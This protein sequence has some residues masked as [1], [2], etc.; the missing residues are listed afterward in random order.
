[1]AQAHWCRSHSE[2]ETGCRPRHLLRADEA[3]T[4]CHRHLRRDPRT[5][6]AGVPVR[7]GK[8]SQGCRDRYPPD[9]DA[10]GHLRSLG[11]H[12]RAP[13]P[14]QERGGEVVKILL[15][16]STLVLACAQAH[17][18]CTSEVGARQ[19]N[20]YVTQCREV[21]PATRPPCNAANAC[22]LIT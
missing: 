7:A 19:A 9:D 20:V 16:V 11:A 15:A 8:L 3:R 12:R 10:H 17:A 4:A 22:A 21:S 18:S 14:Q 13:T 6:D 5:H 1:R 2:S